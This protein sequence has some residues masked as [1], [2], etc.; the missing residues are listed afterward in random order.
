MDK[1]YHVDAVKCQIFPDMW[2]DNEQPAKNVRYV[3]IQ[4]EPGHPSTSTPYLGST[5]GNRQSVPVKLVG[6]PIKPCTPSRMMRL[7][8]VKPVVHQV[9]DD[10]EDEDDEVCYFFLTFSN[11]STLV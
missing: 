9:I 7:Q 5:M 6:S 2:Q 8:Q 11:A 1:N 3:P 4:V 10:E